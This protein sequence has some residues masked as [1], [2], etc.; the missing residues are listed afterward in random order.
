MDPS[1]CTKYP[2]LTLNHG[3]WS[4]KPAVLISN[5]PFFP[6]A[7]ESL[8][9][10]PHGGSTHSRCSVFRTPGAGPPRSTLSSFPPCFTLVLERGLPVRAFSCS[11]NYIH[12]HYLF[13]RMRQ[14]SQQKKK[15]RHSQSVCIIKVTGGT[16]A[17]V[18][19]RHSPFPHSQ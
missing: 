19:Q 9:F 1:R 3:A 17:S 2:L 5:F 16:I 12:T 7:R 11:F 4:Q 10:S 8:L 13:S 18:C 6:R 15:Q 14:P